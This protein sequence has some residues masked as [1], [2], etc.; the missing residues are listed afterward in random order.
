MA[1]TASGT[2]TIAP[3]HRISCIFDPEPSNFIENGPNNIRFRSKNGPEKIN[4][5]IVGVILGQGDLSGPGPR[6]SP[7]LAG[8][9]GGSHLPDIH[10]HIQFRV[11][12]GVV[13]GAGGAGGPLGSPGV[14]LAVGAP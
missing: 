10:I 1:P 8:Y 14:A 2:Q 13:T 6:A 11:E 3:N 7:L 5:V 4:G 9:G 12:V